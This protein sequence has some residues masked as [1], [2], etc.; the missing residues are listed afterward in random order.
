MRTMSSVGDVIFECKGEQLVATPERALVWPAQRSVL[1]ADWHLGKAEVFGY[2]G[3]PIPDGSDSDDMLRLSRLVDRFD[4]EH[5]FVLGDLMHAPPSGR[6]IWPGALASWLD[7]NDQLEMTVVAGNHDR[8]K[9]EDLPNSLGKRLNWC[10]STL[11][12]GPFLLDHEPGDRSDGYV[13]AGHLH[14][15][16]VLRAGRDRI[17]APVYWFQER[18]AVLPA[19]GSFTGGYQV[20]PVNGDRLFLA[21]DDHVEE[22]EF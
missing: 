19:F 3:L 17:R 2:R 22:I 12:A 7:E 1:L 15:V 10:S 14:P 4:A 20:R 6:S 5:V 21:G 11:L 16:W 18:Q 13:L 8:V 9:S